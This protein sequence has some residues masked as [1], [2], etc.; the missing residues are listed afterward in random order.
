[1]SILNH[2]SQPES[3]PLYNKVIVES[4]SQLFTSNVN[5]TTKDAN[6]KY[7]A[8]LNG[9]GCEDIDCLLKVDAKA[10]LDLNEYAN[11]AYFGWSPV[12][13]GV[14]VTEFFLNLFEAKLFNNQVPI[15][16]GTNREEVA[17]DMNIPSNNLTEEEFDSLIQK[18]SPMSTEELAE[19]K[20]L[21]NPEVYSYPAELGEYSIWA[22]MYVRAQT[23]MMVVAEL[24][25]PGH[26]QDLWL[27]RKLLEA[28]SKSIYMY[29]WAHTPNTGSEIFAAH[30]YEVF[31]VFN[32]LVY[33]I[34]EAQ[35]TGNF[36]YRDDATAARTKMGHAMSSYWSSFAVSGDPSP[37]R[38][39]SELG[40]VEWPKFTTD[41][42]LTFMLEDDS[43]GGLRVEQNLL[44]EQC[45]WH[46]QY[47]NSVGEYLPLK[48]EALV[49]ASAT[50]LRR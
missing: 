48:S 46:L 29:Q 38:D 18:Y 6:M 14:S 31:N 41:A 47:A 7:Q 16:I 32:M 21:Y 5:I 10:L 17:G 23:D 36:T 40:M 44:K 28:G 22:W 25:M 8:F 15:L 24:G 4:G 42:E 33:P 11:A 1:M 9:T 50:K 30:G 35:Q 12:I 34:W 37:T 3:Y 27:A 20:Q 49:T 19:L 26:C 39:A 45:D 43:K 13:D 2:L